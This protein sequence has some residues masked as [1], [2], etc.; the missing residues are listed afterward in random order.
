MSESGD[1]P[2]VDRDFDD[3]ARLVQQRQRYR[4]RPKPAVDVINH[5]LA[6]KGYS[7][8]DSA[9][10]LSDTWQKIVGARWKGKTVAGNISRGI[11]EITV[12]SPAIGQHLN[13]QKKQLLKKLS[14]QLPQNKIKDIRF[15]TGRIV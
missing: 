4:R 13:F 1:N 5:L 12:A 15:K 14:E 7:Q 2:Y 6:R 8:T 10:Q 11:L 9:D 3:A